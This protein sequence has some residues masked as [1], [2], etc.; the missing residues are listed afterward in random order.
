MQLV[1]EMNRNAIVL[2]DNHARILK[3]LSQRCQDSVFSA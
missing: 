3:I 1:I 2:V